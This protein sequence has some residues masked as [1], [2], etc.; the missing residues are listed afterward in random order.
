MAKQWISDKRFALPLAAVI[1]AGLATALVA[2]LP[3]TIELALWQQAAVYAA[4]IVAAVFAAS[5]L[6]G[7]A[8]TA[9]TTE[10]PQAV[11]QTS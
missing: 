10:A 8:T 9:S 6:A 1:G 4:L 3:Q 5:K 2:A 11:E 7:Q